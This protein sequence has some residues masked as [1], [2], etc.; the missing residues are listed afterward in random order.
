M[1]IQIGAHAMTRAMQIMQAFTPHGTLGKHVELGAADAGRELGQLYLYMSLEHQGIDMLH[2]FSQRAKGNGTGDVGSA[3]EIL[4]AAVQQQQSFGLEWDIRL[5][6]RFIVY[7][8][9]MIAI[10]GNGVEGDIAIEGLLSPEG[11]QLAVD[12]HLRLFGNVSI[13]VQ[14]LQKLYHSD[15]VFQHRTPKTLLFGGILHGFHP[16]D[17]RLLLYPL[18]GHGLIERVVH[19]VGIH[20]DVIVEIALQ[21]GLHGFVVVHLDVVL[22]EIS[23]DLGCQLLL[24]NI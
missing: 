18:T 14:P 3:V 1:H 13:F 19:L 5:G 16:L 4:G 10:A 9:A 12:G 2:L 8:S 6:R 15:A 23:C 24:I 11:G 20:Q 22:L 17:G 21:P 7:D